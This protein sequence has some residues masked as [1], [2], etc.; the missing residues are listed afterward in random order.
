MHL[1]SEPQHANSLRS[2][3]QA[4]LQISTSTT[5]EDEQAGCAPSASHAL[6][7]GTRAR[8]LKRGPP[9]PAGPSDSSRPLLASRPAAAASFGVLMGAKLCRRAKARIRCGA[10][11][12]S[13][14]NDA[15]HCRQNAVTAMH[16]SARLEARLLVQ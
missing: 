16:C 10:A 12:H 15:V 8:L 14:S 2:R 13:D 4:G 7:V 3:S 5:A 11:G 1:Q 9:L 6:A